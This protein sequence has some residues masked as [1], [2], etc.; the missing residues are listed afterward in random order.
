MHAE[1]SVFAL[2]EVDPALLATLTKYGTLEDF[3]NTHI[4]DTVNE[5]VAAF[6]ADAPAAT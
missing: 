6:R 5:A 1:D 3:D 2:A 4:Y